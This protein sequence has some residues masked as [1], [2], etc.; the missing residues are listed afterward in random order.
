LSIPPWHESQWHLNVA[1]VTWSN[2]TRWL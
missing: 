1:N 2:V